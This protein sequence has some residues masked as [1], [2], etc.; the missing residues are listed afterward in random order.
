MVPKVTKKGRSF[1][2]AALYYL[3][4]KGA[5]T[6]ERVAFTHTLNLATEDPHMA[7]RMMAYTA[8]HQSQIKQAAGEV[9]T[10]RKLTL[11]V[12]VYSLAWHP[13]EAP[14]REEMIE[15]AHQSLKTLDL[16]GHEIVMAA[17]NDEEHPHI[18]VIVNRV[19]P[20]TGIAAPLSNDR[21]RLS[22]WAEAYERERGQIFC[23]RRVEN[24]ERRRNGEWVKD[25]LSRHAA[26]YHR[27]QREHT[28]QVV[29]RR[30]QQLKG[31]SDF[32]KKQHQ[33]L[34]AASNKRIAER[35]ATLREQNRPAWATLY[36][37]QKR[38]QQAFV[39]SQRTAWG[40]LRYHLKTRDPWAGTT[41]RTPLP[42]VIAGAFQAIGSDRKSSQALDRK[43]KRQRKA[44]GE[45][46]NAQTRKALQEINTDYKTDRQALITQQHRERR[47]TKEA[48]R[49]QSQQAARDIASGR[50]REEFDRKNRYRVFQDIQKHKREQ[51]AKA[52][53]EAAKEAKPKRE[54]RV[55]RD[56][57]EETARDRTGRGKEKDAKAKRKFSAFRDMKEQDRDRGRDKGRDRNQGRTRGPRRPPDD[58]DRD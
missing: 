45:R 42:R 55:F 4:D 50:A 39:Q 28:R 34:T 30:E 52:R 19:H 46:V 22:V 41:T 49:L 33:T 10:G 44:L 48:H 40:R 12:Y 11:P 35:R 47:A 53:R 1:K 7:A 29:E 9:A 31:L 43:Q 26:E 6:D 5:L 23:D 27:W 57:K 38:E 18:H 58:R 56:M 21:L 8:M 13:T 17:H 3:H 54:F 25:R 16:D 2:G 51:D 36:Q 14:T 24:N 32:H 15:A 20:K 37:R